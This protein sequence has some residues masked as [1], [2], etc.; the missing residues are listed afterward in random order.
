MSVCVARRR[1][2]ALKPATC[3]KIQE[4]KCSNFSKIGF[5]LLVRL[6]KILSIWKKIKI[7]LCVFTYTAEMRQTEI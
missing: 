7:L 5:D 1:K 2:H 3:I 6:S 4:R